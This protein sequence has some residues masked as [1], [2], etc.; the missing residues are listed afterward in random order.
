MRVRLP[1]FALLLSLH[2]CSTSKPNAT[3]VLIPGQETDAFTREP[4]PTQLKIHAVS[5]AGEKQTLASMPWP[6]GTFDIGD[7]PTDQ[8]AALE[9]VGST[10]AGDAVVRGRTLPMA[11]GSLDGAEVP[12]FMGRV[13]E[14]AR[15][16]GSLPVSRTRGVAGIV[17][18]LYL[19]TSGGTDVLDASGAPVTAASAIAYDL[20]LWAPLQYTASSNLPRTPLTM[21]IVSLHF[22]LLID[23][24]G[25]TWI[26]FDTTENVE[27]TAPAGMTFADVAGGVPVLGEDGAAYV[28]GATRAGGTPTAAVLR[29]GS[30]L[31][32][33]ALT[34][35]APRAGASA[36][37][38]SGKGLVVAGGNASAPGVEWL[39]TD[40]TQFVA[41]P[42]APDPVAG[43]GATTLDATHVLLAGGVDD[44]GAPA[45][46]RMI[47]PSCA[48]ACSAQAISGSEA[49]ALEAA[50]AWALSA[51]KALVVGTAPAAQP[52]AGQT[53]VVM[54]SLNAL[55]ATTKLVVLREPRIGATAAALP[56]GTIAITGGKSPSGQAVR[57]VEL[58]TPPE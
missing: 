46:A 29:V 9:A 27:A 34:L 47:D 33:S 49:T 51:T 58:F 48:S 21:A 25:A 40:A 12:L 38:S 53:R 8:F 3:L 54:V 50:S 52:D 11:L 55:A 36:A 57:S 15:P 26:D 23:A 7:L 37:W 45:P 39:A 5:I 44:K 14:M 35:T 42:F 6:T 56:M 4:K 17:G 41:L 18:G 19:V 20:G 1:I 31:S 16:P 32:L 43:G 10:A 2:A 28:V 22:G 24:Q 30:D 13:G